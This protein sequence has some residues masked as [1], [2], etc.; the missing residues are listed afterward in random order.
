MA[1]KGWYGYKV[2]TPWSGLKIKNWKSEVDLGG[3][4]LKYLSILDLG[5][6]FLVNNC[7]YSQLETSG[8]PQFGQKITSLSFGEK[9]KRIMGLKEYIGPFKGVYRAF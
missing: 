4:F 3:G 5:F 1:I 9:Q 2:V 8:N 7:D 6:A